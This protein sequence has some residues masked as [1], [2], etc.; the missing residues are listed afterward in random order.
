MV[1]TYMEVREQLVG[2]SSLPSKW[3][4][5]LK[6]RPSDCLA[7]GFT[8]CELSCLGALVSEGPLDFALC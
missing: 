4:L 8:H 5:E 3:V 6:L 2:I 1:H 7:S